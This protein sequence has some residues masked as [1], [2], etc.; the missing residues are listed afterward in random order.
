MF[1]IQ[2]SGIHFFHNFIHCEC[3]QTTNSQLTFTQMAYNRFDEHVVR[4]G[5]KGM[6]IHVDVKATTIM[7]Q[8]W[9]A[10]TG[11]DGCQYVFVRFLV[12]HHRHCK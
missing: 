11:D 6:T 5:E 9:F 4:T 3:R 7:D 1:E 12:A 2:F 10:C 8:I